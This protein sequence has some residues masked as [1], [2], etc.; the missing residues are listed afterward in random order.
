MQ[1]ED[2]AVA[3]YNSTYRQLHDNAIVRLATGPLPGIPC[4]IPNA[5]RSPIERHFRPLKRSLSIADRSKNTEYIMLNYS[6]LY[7]ERLGIPT[8]KG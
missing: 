3:I 5:C 6:N 4:R 1:F 2:Q 8:V 7:T